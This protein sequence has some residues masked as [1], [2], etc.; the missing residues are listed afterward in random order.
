MTRI[1]SWQKAFLVDV[2]DN[3][4][5]HVN[6]T[7][8]DELSSANSEITLSV[9][10]LSGQVVATA[11]IQPG[12]SDVDFEAS[13]LSAGRYKVFAR[14]QAGYAVVEIAITTPPLPDSFLSPELVIPENGSVVGE[15][16]Q[17]IT[18]QFPTAM[19]AA[20]AELS[21]I[22]INNQPVT[23]VELFQPNVL[24]AY[25]DFS[26]FEDG[27]T[28]VFEAQ[29]GAFQS[30]LGVPNDRIVSSF[31]MDS[32]GPQVLSTSIVNGTVLPVR[33][34]PDPGEIRCDS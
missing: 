27:Q 29:P 23:A 18:M 26:S 34:K 6:A 14:R 32:R 9:E 33:M 15:V 20:S 8:L 3:G 30:L 11:E 21:R 19:N 28:V 16:P 1:D 4:S 22:T 17:F 12:A 25:Y 10:D 5:I 24:R 7:I 2:A 31:Q 13:N